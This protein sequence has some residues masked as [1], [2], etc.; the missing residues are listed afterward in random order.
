MP[1]IADFGLACKT[2]D[3]AQMSRRC[4]SAGFVAPEVCLGTPYDC[5]VDTFGAGV[6]LFF[7]FS[8][9][10]PFSS[11]DRDSAATMRKT[12]KCSLHLQRPPFSELS[13][14]ARNMLRQLICKNQEERLSAEAALEHSWMVRKA[15]KTGISSAAPAKVPVEAGE[16]DTAGL[17]APT[18]MP[19]SDTG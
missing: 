10:L 15:E 18:P 5:K 11:P 7:M 1:L 2:S 16:A 3:Q 4:G 13:S 12:V 17:V 8:K 6:I 9:E 14:R 19:P